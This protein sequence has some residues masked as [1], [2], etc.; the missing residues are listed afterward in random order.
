MSDA[1][2]CEAEEGFHLVVAASISKKY[3]IY[4]KVHTRVFFHGVR[5]VKVPI[6]VKLFN[7]ESMIICLIAM[8]LCYAMTQYANA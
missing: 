6:Q 8:Q 5:I 4:V 7:N 3:L 2:S 1:D